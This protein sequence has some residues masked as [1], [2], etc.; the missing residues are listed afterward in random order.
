MSKRKLNFCIIGIGRAGQF[1]LSSL[2]RMHAA[3]LLYVVDPRL[4]KSDQFVI[5]NE[6]NLV[7]LQTA[8]GDANLDAVIVSTPTQF[9]FSYITQALEAGKHVFAEKPLGKKVDEINTCYNLA[10]KNSLALHLGFQRRFDHNF[11]ALKEG[12]KKMGQIRI[13][14]T[15]SRDNPKPSLDYLKISGNIFHDMLIHDFD[16][17]SYL[18]GPKIPIQIYAT[19]HAYDPAIRD[20]KDFDTVMVNLHYEDGL[21]VSIDTSRTAPYG[22]DQRIELFTAEGM[23]IAENEKENTVQIYSSEGMLQTKSKHSFPER[24]PDAYFKEIEYFAASIGSSNLFTVS[25][26]ECLLAHLIADAAYESVMSGKPVRFK[27]L[28]KSQILPEQE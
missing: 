18:L 7:D 19:G 6:L 24:Y 26:T 14:K 3:T 25:R 11:Q 5:D 9:H 10:E 21:I 27:E 17:L 12:L 13:I 16:M 20:M 8:L 15:S 4:D 23:L 22:Y 28:F 2:Q 1:H